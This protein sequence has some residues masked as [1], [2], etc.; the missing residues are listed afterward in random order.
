[1]GKARNIYVSGLKMLSA[2]FVVFIHVQFPGDFG[3]TM[4]CVSRFAVPTFFL[5]SGYY[6]YQQEVRVLKRRLLKILVLALFSNGIFF[7]WNCFWKRMILHEDVGEFIKGI[8]SIKTLSE[9]IF[10]GTNPFSAHLWYLSAMIWIYIVYILVIKFWENGK[11]ARYE[12][13]YIIAVCAFM[14]QIAFGLKAEAIGLEIDYLVYRYFIFFGFPFFSFGLFLHEY[15]DRIVERYRFTNGCALVMIIV[16]ILV[17]LLQWFGIG[18]VEVPIGMLLVVATLGLLAFVKPGPRYSRNVLFTGMEIVSTAV[19]IIH[20]LVR[21]VINTYKDTVD[22]FY[23]IRSA[24]YL[25]P[26]IVLGLS[27]VIGMA[28]AVVS[29]TFRRTVKNQ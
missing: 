22:V 19:Y 10:M 2:S 17:S 4:D 15:G 11:K 25:Y 5:I 9:F 3:K 16:G 18:K 7:L 12:Y 23:W 8:F 27:I 6:S 24:E 13:I 26:L 1:M 28:A 14:F 21:N 29:I 20:P